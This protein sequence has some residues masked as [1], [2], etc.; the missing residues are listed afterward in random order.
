MIYKP[1]MQKDDGEDNRNI[2]ILNR[3]TFV[4]TDG[5]SIVSYVDWT[6]LDVVNV[7][8]STVDGSPFGF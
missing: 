2:G 1:S 8:Y 6:M 7:R 3:E 5:V 4:G